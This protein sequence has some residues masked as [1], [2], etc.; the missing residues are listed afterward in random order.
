[1]NQLAVFV[2]IQRAINGR[3]VLGFQQRLL[4]A[5]AV[6]RTGAG[7]R[8]GK[9]VDAIVIG[10]GKEVRLY[11]VGL[12]KRIVELLHQLVRVIGD[13]VGD[14]V[15]AFGL[16]CRNKAQIGRQRE[17]RRTDDGHI[18]TH[19]VHLTGQNGCFGVVRVNDQAVD[20]GV[21]ALRDRTGHVGI[22]R[23]VT[24]DDQRFIAGVG[25]VLHNNVSAADTVV[26]V[27]V[28]H[29][30]FGCADVF[31]GKL[32]DDLTH[33]GV[34]A[35]DSEE[36]R[37]GDLFDEAGRRSAGQVGD[38]CLRDNAFHRHGVRTSVRTQQRDDRLVAHELVDNVHSRCRVVRVVLHND[39]ERATE[40]AAGSVDF[41]DSHLDALH[42]ALAVERRRAGDCGG[43]AD[44]DGIGACGSI[45]CGSFGFGG[46]GFSG[47][48]RRVAGLFC[49]GAAACGAGEH[50][51]QREKHGNKSFHR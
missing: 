4:D 21:D 17:G 6:S 36:P 42:G 13:E 41:A 40:H 37:V 28:N 7:D 24:F 14:T 22:V 46:C 30:E 33:K 47:G 3:Q 48:F 19:F 23:V 50:Q 38:F 43:N 2:G 15:E 49:L 31:D 10:C 39:L 44:A 11:I 16:F 5:G 45:A 20:A 12:D 26:V 34:R 35:S 29:A 8:I 18:Q 9:D 25:Q 27:V 32:A 51:K 1:M